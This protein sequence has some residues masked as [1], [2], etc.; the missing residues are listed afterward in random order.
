MWYVVWVRTGQEEKVL[1]MCRKVLQD[2]CFLP[3]YERARKQ[4]GRWIEVERLLFPGYIFFDSDNAEE[5]VDGLRKIPEFTKV[6]GYG[7]RPIALYPHEVAFLQKYTDEDRVMRM[8]RGFLEGDKLVVTEGPLKYYK[9]KVVH[10]DRHKRVV[11]LEVEFFGRTLRVE[12][13][14]EVVMKV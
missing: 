4:D 3:R 13:G 12:V 6:L 11:T 9:G 2:H 1:Q 10:I 7:G 14:V 5:L 8:S